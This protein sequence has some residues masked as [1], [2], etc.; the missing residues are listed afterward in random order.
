[1]NV[2]PAA[3]FRLSCIRTLTF[4]RHPGFLRI[5]KKKLPKFCAQ[6]IV[7]RSKRQQNPKAHEH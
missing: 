7:R 6:C 2:K 5:L 1:M 3:T 4:N